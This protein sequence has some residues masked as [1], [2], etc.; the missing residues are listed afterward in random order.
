MTL[1]PKATITAIAV[2]LGSVACNDDS[3]NPSSE[4][5]H[6]SPNS[7]STNSA[8]TPSE[9]NGRSFNLHSA[10]GYTPMDAS[11]VAVS[12]TAD[13]IGLGAGCNRMGG[14]YQVEDDKLVVSGILSTDMACDDGLG[15]QEDWFLGFVRGG[16]TVH[17][18]GDWL[19]L[20]SG[21]TTLTFLDRVIA[22][23]DRPLVGT[24][25]ILNAR[26]MA[27][28]A[29]SMVLETNPRV[30]F[31]TG[32]AFSPKDRFSLHSGCNVGEGAYEATATKIT[33]S[34]FQLGDTDCSFEGDAK[35]NEEQW[36]FLM[37]VFSGTANYRIQASQLLIEHTDGTGIHASAQ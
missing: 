31:Q 11:L 23:P 6:D 1:S 25:W 9:L 32:G 30:F 37:Q 15:L 17:L 26:L 10:E 27:P 18:D 5:F 12:F 2:L 14:E 33:F 36:Q 3:D 34:S 4:T 19:T 24:N 8:V 22:D 7:G 21:S 29:M 35:E 16:P 13:W 28:I 20:A